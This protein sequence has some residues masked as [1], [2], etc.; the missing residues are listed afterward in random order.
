MHTLKTPHAIVHYHSDWSAIQIELKD[1]LQPL[2]I[3]D[4]K[5]IY[6]AFFRTYLEDQLEQLKPDD[7]IKLGYHL[8][9]EYT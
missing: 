8:G 5:E 1:P 4:I 7:L 3:M 2:D 6:A 9:K